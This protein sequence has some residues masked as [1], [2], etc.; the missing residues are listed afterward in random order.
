VLAAVYFELYYHSE[1][2]KSYLD[3]ADYYAHKSGGVAD[4]SG[5]DNLK[6]QAFNI[7]GAVNNYK[8]DY[9]KAKAILTRALQLDRKVN[10]T[11][12]VSILTNL[13]AAHMELGN[14]DSAL[15]YAEKGLE[16]ASSNDDEVFSAIN[17]R[18]LTSIFETMG[19]EKKAAQ[20]KAHYDFLASKKDAMVRSLMTKQLLLNYEKQQADSKVLGL[21][22]DRVYFFRLSRLLI[23]GLMVA[24]LVA[25]LVTYL[26]VRNHQKKKKVIEQQ[27]ELER[28]EREYHQAQA[29]IL[30]QEKRI[31]RERAE[32]YELAYRVKEHK[33]LN[34]TIQLA[35][36]SRIN[37]SIKKKL[38][39]FKYSLPDKLQQ[40]NFNSEVKALCKL[41]Q[42]PFDLFEQD[43]MDTHK[44]FYDALKARHSDLTDEDLR[45]CALLK[46]D[47]SMVEITHLLL[48]SRDQI[49]NHISEIK[50]KLG[51]KSDEE[52]VAYLQKV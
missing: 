8:D 30:D 19:N 21:Y 6:A 51:F 24:V 17:Y 38:L 29:T 16:W 15:Y 1:D 4:A 50:D 9:Q 20:M 43:F 23:V 36:Q 52:L 33:L 48:R 12:E 5:D 10:D 47:V 40:E 28:K 26:V 46:T 32:K 41:S 42:N 39:P 35:N 18:L 7:I 25:M 22:E 45:L 2:N 13:S 3:S 44:G 49:E 31:E 37:Q 11:P 27:L 34:R 14:L